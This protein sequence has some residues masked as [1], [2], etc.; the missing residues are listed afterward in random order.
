MSKNNTSDELVMDVLNDISQNEP[1]KEFYDKEEMRDTLNKLVCGINWH[2]EIEAFE[3]LSHII[4]LTYIAIRKFTGTEKLPII[5]WKP[6]LEYY[7]EEGKEILNNTDSAEYKVLANFYPMTNELKKCQQIVS[8]L[9][10]L[11]VINK[12]TKG[13]NNLVLRQMGKELYEALSD[14]FEK[15]GEDKYMSYKESM[16]A[17]KTLVLNGLSDM[18]RLENME[19]VGNLV[20]NT[21]VKIDPA[22]SMLNKEPK[23]KNKTEN[24]ST[25]V[26]VEEVS[27]PIMIEPVNTQTETAGVQSEEV[28]PL[29]KRA[30]EQILTDTPEVAEVSEEKPVEETSVENPVVE[31]EMAGEQAVE[32]PTPIQRRIPLTQ[33]INRDIIEKLIDG[34]GFDSPKALLPREEWL[35]A[36]IG[37]FQDLNTRYSMAERGKDVEAIDFYKTILLD[38][39]NSFDRQYAITK[40]VN[41]KHSRGFKPDYEKW[42]ET[43]TNIKHFREKLKN[44]GK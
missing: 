41:I 6:I 19:A 1:L 28:T 27:E 22:V 20:S 32:N 16:I 12:H 14:T 5:F 34:N 18:I 17:Y 21:P 31:V 35:K 23:S 24:I 7:F 38:L 4:D 3:Y 29:V 33:T 13:V 11:V 10:T 26:V 30:V 42:E 39:F 44:T 25:P 2:T 36:F 8:K 9:H 37:E 43:E 15:I 40:R